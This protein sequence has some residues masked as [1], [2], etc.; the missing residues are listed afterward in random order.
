[1]KSKTAQLSIYIVLGILLIVIII[2]TM[3]FSS[4]G[5]LLKLFLKQTDQPVPYY[6]E[7]CMKF[8]VV[9]GIEI[10]AAQG[11]FI[12]SFSPNLTT[13]NRTFAY[14]I[15]NS[16]NTSPSRTFMEYELAAYIE[17][18]IDGCINQSSLHIRKAGEP[19]AEVTIYPE[20]VFARLYYQL[21]SQV[22]DTVYTF[23]EF[24]SQHYIPFGR[25]IQLKDIIVK[26]LVDYPNLMLLDKLYGTDFEMYINP[27]SGKIKVI[28]MVNT[29]ARLRND[30]LSF[31]FAMHDDHAMHETL[32]FTNELQDVTVFVG[33]PYLTQVT[34][35][36]RC[37]YYDNTILFDIDE[38]TGIISYVPD[39]LDRGMYNVT[40]TVDDDTFKVSKKY[41]LTVI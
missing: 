6:V 23:N 14:S 33:I 27:Y 22:G 32:A 36:H 41:K 20:S 11:G 25:M 4:D 3:F 8:M 26:D 40:I 15:Y 9:D 29:S 18:N 13:T 17:N 5:S 12:Y 21:E 37:K 2:M 39:E 19:R 31:F 24:G 7:E 28:Q 38:D 1:M 30:P 35:N 34:C 10:L 16:V